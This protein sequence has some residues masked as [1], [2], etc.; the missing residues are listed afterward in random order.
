LESEH[1][2][3]LSILICIKKKQS[4]SNHQMSR[5]FYSY[6]KKTLG[7]RCHRRWKRHVAPAVLNC[8]RENWDDDKYSSPPHM[9]AE[10][11][12][13]S[14]SSED[15]LEWDE[16]ETM[17]LCHSVLH[18]YN[19][20]DDSGKKPL[21]SNAAVPTT[22]MAYSSIRPKNIKKKRSGLS[23]RW[24]SP[25][26]KG[27]GQ[28][29]DT[30]D[31]LVGP[32]PAPLFRRETLAMSSSS[33]LSGT[34]NEELFTI[35]FVPSADLMEEESNPASLQADIMTP[36]RW[37]SN[38]VE[39]QVD[40]TYMLRINFTPSY[41]STDYM[42]INSCD[43]P[44]ASSH[45]ERA[46][47]LSGIKTT[48][49]PTE[50][51]ALHVYGTSSCLA[52]HNLLLRVLTLVVVAAASYLSRHTGQFLDQ[53]KI[54]ANVINYMY[55]VMDVE[56]RATLQRRYYNHHI[57][58]SVIRTVDFLDSN[59]NEIGVWFSKAAS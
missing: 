45:S 6:V 26:I 27:Y 31:Q 20:S 51:C 30:Y 14:T 17:E 40:D 47:Y 41:D 8:R 53:Y 1:F 22:L 21:T 15:I 4:M 13:N 9:P 42:S 25:L 56:S 57:R 28:N 58:N 46:P 5:F 7:R 24:N 19:S 39:P 18:Y 49:S 35:K 2:I 37:L 10:N 16:E 44:I 3:L 54:S 12:E 36:V 34:Q 59:H 50:K 32:T 52:R 29:A 33:L 43:S 11:D 38:D 23:V 48:L 55:S